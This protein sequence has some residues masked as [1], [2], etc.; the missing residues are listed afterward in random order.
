[1]DIKTEILSLLTPIFGNGVKKLID[2]NYE[3]N[4]AELIELA[5]HMLTGYMGKDY[6]EKQLKK[7]I[8]ISKPINVK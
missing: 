8:L 4:E 7:I 3:N 1:M 5:R 2:D 6:A